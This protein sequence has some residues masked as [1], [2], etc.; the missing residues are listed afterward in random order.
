MKGI[1]ECLNWMLDNPMKELKSY[2]MANRRYNDKCK[3]FEIYAGGLG[4]WE[5]FN[6]FHYFNFGIWTEVE[7]PVDFITAYQDCLE[8]GNTYKAVDTKNVQGTN[9]QIMDRRSNSVRVYDKE[10]DEVWLDCMWIKQ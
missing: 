1:K 5:A 2:G 8:N 9:Q 4:P 6:N 7:E 3:T 10:I